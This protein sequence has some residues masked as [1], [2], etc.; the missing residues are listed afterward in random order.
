MAPPG[1]SAPGCRPLVRL[2][3]DF[4]RIP[5]RLTARFPIR[6]DRMRGEIVRPVCTRK[7]MAPGGGGA[8]PR[9]SVELLNA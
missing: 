3:R 8:K 9:R 4:L 7:P 2:P 6:G 1:V 5:L